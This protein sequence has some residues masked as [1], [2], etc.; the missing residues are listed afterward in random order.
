MGSFA[1]YYGE[2]HVPEEKKAEL[3]ERMLTLLIQGG[4]MDYSTAD[5]FGYS[6][7]LL[8]APTYDENDQV[9]VSYNYFEDDR[10]EAAGYSAAKGKFWSNKVGSSKFAL[11]VCAA[12][13]LLE[14]YSDTYMISEYDG[15][16]YNEVTTIGWLNHLF[17]EDPILFQD[18]IVRINAMS[19][20]EEVVEYVAE[21]FSQWDMG[22]ELVYRFMMAVRRKVK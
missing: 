17:N 10:W 8:K 18:T 2:C 11:V 1:G 16:V 14:F 3:K 13:V 20:L 7:S 22:S 19:S 4:M 9:V 15:D 6:L 5:M 12:Y 21:S